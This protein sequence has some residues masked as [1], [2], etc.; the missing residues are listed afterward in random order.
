MRKI[1]KSK[2]LSESLRS[3]RK[4]HNKNKQKITYIRLNEVN[5]K[6]TIPT[7]KINCSF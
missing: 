6:R 3:R 1:I 7:I 5:Q 2:P 4:N